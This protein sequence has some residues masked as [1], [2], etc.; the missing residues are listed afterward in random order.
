MSLGDRNVDGYGIENYGALEN[1]IDDIN[2]AVKGINRNVARIAGMQESDTKRGKVIEEVSLRDAVIR[3]K[4][5][6]S[7]YV[8]D[9][10]L[11]T[12]IYH[13]Q[14][15]G[16]K[17]R[18]L[19]VD[20]HG[21]T[22]AFDGGAFQESSGDIRFGK[23]RANP[24]EI[25]QGVIRRANEE[26]F[27]RPTVSG[28]GTVSL[29]SSFKFIQLLRF[30]EPKKVVL[31]KGL[32]LASAGD[33]KF[34]TTRNFNLSYMLFSAKSVFQTD[35]RGSGVIALELP[36]HKDELVK[37]IVTPDKPYRV[38]GDYVLYWVGDLERR[39]RKSSS[40]FGSI[41]SGTGLVEEY[42]GSGYVITAPTLGYYKTLSR[43]LANTGYGVSDRTA[44]V[45][46]DADQGKR[47]TP[48]LKKIF[49]R[50]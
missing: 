40:I 21:G 7:S 25:I 15:L 39:V 1:K 44:V 13:A 24:K 35:V 30:Q 10:S 9:L 5:Y 16:M 3:V 32:Y 49:T 28:N 4:E 20:L 19:E 36:V 48:L 23:I 37:H 18:Q 22:L 14:Q 17:L 26:T 6:S 12:N 34:R 46:E 38:N 27:F 11:A 42:S 2:S 47:K 31:E 41:A 8:G 43:D 29:E 50:Q 45:G 33:F